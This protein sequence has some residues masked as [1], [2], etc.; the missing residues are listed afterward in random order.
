MI[1]AGYKRHKKFH[2]EGTKDTKVFVGCALRTDRSR[3]ISRKERKGRIGR[4]L[5]F[6]DD[7]SRPVTTFRLLLKCLDAPC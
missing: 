7:G 1:V 2:H 4:A 3:N 6:R 5:S